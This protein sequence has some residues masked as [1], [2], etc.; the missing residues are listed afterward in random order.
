[1][2]LLEATGLRREH[3]VG[4][5]ETFC[6]SKQGTLETTAEKR[7][8]SMLLRA[9]DLAVIVGEG[10]CRAATAAPAQLNGELAGRLEWLEAHHA[11]KGLQGEQ[12]TLG[13]LCEVA[14]ELIGLIADVPPDAWRRRCCRKAVHLGR[15]GGYIE[16][17]QGVRYSLDSDISAAAGRET[18]VRLGPAWRPPQRTRCGCSSRAY[19]PRWHAT[20]RSCSSR[21]CASRHRSLRSARPGARP[22]GAASSACAR[23][24][25]RSCG[26]GAACASPGAEWLNESE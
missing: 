14:R 12:P 2:A 26:G 20:T 17:C 24:S 23:L 10:L 4:R 1:M 9:G 3:I 15:Q 6:L 7:F 22:T 11:D 16:G 19:A 5:F 18:H 21:A 25:R 13:K 8:E